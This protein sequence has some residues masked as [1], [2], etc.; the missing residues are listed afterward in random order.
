V[1][2]LESLNTN[3]LKQAGYIKMEPLRQTRLKLSPY[4]RNANAYWQRATS[5]HRIAG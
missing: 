2:E 3:Y 5:P 4:T 1:E